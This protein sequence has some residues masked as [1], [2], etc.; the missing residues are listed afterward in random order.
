V[1]LHNICKF[2]A[3]FCKFVANGEKYCNGIEDTG[4]PKGRNP[5]KTLLTCRRESVRL[6]SLVKKGAEELR[7][8]TQ[9]A[10]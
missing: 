10:K 9:I 2:I 8:T 1:V 6:N 4:N 5:D 3:F 7:N